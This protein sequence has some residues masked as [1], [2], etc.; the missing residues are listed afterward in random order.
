[1]EESNND[2]REKNSELHKLLLQANKMSSLGEMSAAVAHELR[3]GLSAMSMSMDLLWNSCKGCENLSRNQN[4]YNTFK[5]EITRSSE[6]IENLLD[7]SKKA[8]HKKEPVDIEVVIGNILS[9]KT[10]DMNL[11]SIELKKI[12]AGVPKIKANKDSMKTVFLN[13]I[14]NAVQAMEEGGGLLEVS[15]GR[16]KDFIVVEVADTGKGISKDNDHL[17]W[18][19]FFTTKGDRGTGIGL[20]LTKMEIDRHGGTITLNRE[21]EKGT[22][23]LVKLPLN[24][25]SCDTN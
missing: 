11:A 23:F 17:I 16:E 19:P 15:T 25:N 6:I 2:L 20:F 10:K 24:G 21:K 4:Y 3:G 13:L 7:L 1:M 5:E 18:E 14:G 9:F 8:V 22:S 12:F